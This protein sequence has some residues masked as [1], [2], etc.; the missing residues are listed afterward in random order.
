MV[1][2]LRDN[3]KI[4]LRALPQHR[5]LQAYILARRDEL[6]GAGSSGGSGAKSDPKGF[7]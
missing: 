1:I 6:T 2:T 4:E 5:E 7:A 3:S